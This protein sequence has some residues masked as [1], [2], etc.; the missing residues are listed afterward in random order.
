VVTT[1]TATAVEVDKVEEDFSK[2]KIRQWEV[3]WFGIDSDG[4]V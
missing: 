4:D 3:Q 2:L 1:T